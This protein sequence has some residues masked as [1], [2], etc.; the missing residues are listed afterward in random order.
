MKLIYVTTPHIEMA[1][2]IAN[3]LV[4]KKLVAC[5]NIVPQIESIFE[6]EGE[7]KTIHECQLF[8][9]T[10]ET[11]VDVVLQRV[12]DIHKYETP[13]ILVLPIQGGLQSFIRWVEGT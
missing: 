8:L 6:W 7:I 4:K 2:E 5:A 9:K 12:K 1:R 11:K 10:A 13:C 3:H